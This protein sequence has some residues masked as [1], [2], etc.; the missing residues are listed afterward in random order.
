MLEEYLNPSKYRYKYMKKMFLQPEKF[1]EYIDEFKNL[2]PATVA[3]KLG[4]KESSFEAH[5][6]IAQIES[7]R[8][9]SKKLS[10]FISCEKFIFPDSLSY[11]QATHQSVALF[12]TSLVPRDAK[13]LDMTAGLGIDCFMFALR[14]HEVTACELDEVR[15]DALIHNGKEL[16]LSQ[17][18][19]HHGDSIAFLKDNADVKPD[20]IFIDPARRGEGNKKTY[21]FKD[22]VPNMI[23]LSP[24]LLQQ[25]DRVLVKASPIIDITKAIDDLPN[26]A[27]VYVIGVAGECKEVLLELRRGFEGQISLE[28][29]D[30]S[31]ESFSL[32]QIADPSF[33][34]KIISRFICNHTGESKKMGNAGLNYAELEDLTTG[35]LYDPNACV[36]KLNAG[37]AITTQFEGLK[38]ISA[39]TDLYWSN[40]FFDEFPGRI[41]E[42]EKRL[43]GKDLKK[44]KGTEVNVAVRNYPLKA[45]EIRKK[46]GLKEGNSLF[47]YAFRAGKKENPI[48]LLCKKLA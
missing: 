48:A 22:C 33:N 12:H 15:G 21:F 28:A 47:L 31:N 41:M 36:H 18:I 20:V 16:N 19:I 39:N 8:K 24:T 11:E 3:L 17:L 5:D 43:E 38:K 13:V 9:G 30:L 32:E 40:Q 34:P 37:A 1:I 26:V 45:D 6:V 35:F 44:L 29:I 14:G 23:E 27:K 10:A 2:D 25:A 46:Y 4:G 7:R 42:I